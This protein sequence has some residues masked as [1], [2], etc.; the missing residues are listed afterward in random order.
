MCGN[1][2][3]SL[4]T[5]TRALLCYVVPATTAHPDQAGTSEMRWFVHCAC[6][7]IIF[8]ITASE[9]AYIVTELKATKTTCFSSL[10]SSSIRSYIAK[11]I[12]D[13]LTTL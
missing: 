12:F 13:I 9:Y 2:R 3:M 4:W 5:C 1:T 10:N 8:P 6:C 7:I 11:A